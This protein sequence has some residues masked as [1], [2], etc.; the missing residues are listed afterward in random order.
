[1]NSETGVIQ[2]LEMLS[3]VVASSELIFHVDI[4][5][6]FGK[7]QL[8]LKEARI[9][10]VSFSAHKIGGPKGIG[11]LYLNDK[12]RRR[13]RPLFFGGGADSLRSGTMPTPLIAGFGTACEL[14]GRADLHKEWGQ[15]A[16]LRMCFLSVIK[17]RGVRFDLN[18]ASDHTIPHIINLRFHKV[19]SEV[20]I[21]ALEG[22][23]IASGSAC[24]SN[25]MQA[26][27]VLKGLGLTDEQANCSVRVSISPTIAEDEIKEAAGI[28]A[29]KVLELQL[30]S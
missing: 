20:L 11:G 13:L 17:L 22:V 24:N 21:S 15:V 16:K 7:I 2:D 10:C 29:A 14:R 23:C 25:N 3:E 4:V 18:A 28:I 12:A 1:V 9:D 30:L 6:S 27:Y 8:D 5:Q 26:S 19:R